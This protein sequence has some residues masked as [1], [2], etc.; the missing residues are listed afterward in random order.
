MKLNCGPTPEQRRRTKYERL[1]T[2][3]RHFAWLPIRV[4]DGDCRWLEFVERRGDCRINPYH[5]DECWTF[6]FRAAQPT[7]DDL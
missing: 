6:E 4:A 3:H 5:F 7:L 2:W 1:M